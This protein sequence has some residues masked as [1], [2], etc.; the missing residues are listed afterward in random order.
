[1]QSLLKGFQVRVLSA[2]V[3]TLLSACGGVEDIRKTISMEYLDA[4]TGKPVIY[5]AGIDAPEVSDA[6]AIPQLPA[7]HQASNADINELVKPPSLLPPEQ[8]PS[9]AD[10]DDKDDKTAMASPQ[11]ETS[12]A[13]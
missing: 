12:D 5:P 3:L 1:M 10:E 9:T 2:A 7:G 11:S 8:Q 6:F 4:K 13:E